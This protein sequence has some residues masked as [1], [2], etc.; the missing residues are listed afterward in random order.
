[1]L[2]PV[3]VKYRTGFGDREIYGQL[4]ASSNTECLVVYAPYIVTYNNG[5][6]VL[7]VNPSVNFPLPI[8]VERLV[9]IKTLSDADHTSYS[10]ALKARYS[11]H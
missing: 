3:L 9:E 1:M 2:G 11:V 6:R 10:N 4:D 5:V 8:E 7:H